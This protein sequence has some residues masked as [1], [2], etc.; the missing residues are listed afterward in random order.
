MSLFSWFSRNEELDQTT[1]TLTNKQQP[2]SFTLN[3]KSMWPV[4]RVR[5]TPST[6]V[7]ANKDKETD[8]IN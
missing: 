1:L 2:K 3:A 4:A 5:C 8:L 6:L 7:D